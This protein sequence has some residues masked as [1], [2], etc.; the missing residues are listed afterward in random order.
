MPGEATWCKESSK[1]FSGWRMTQPALRQALEL[2]LEQGG[3]KALC[4]HVIRRFPR[5]TTAAEDIVQ[6]VLQEVLAGAGGSGFEVGGGEQRAARHGSLE[7]GDAQGL[8]P[9]HT[10]LRH[11]RQLVRWRALDALRRAE[12]VALSA[13]DQ[14][15]DSSDL[16]AR[17]EVRDRHQL[18][19]SGQYAEAE[20]RREQVLLLSDVLREFTAWCE[21]P[22][23]RGGLVMKELYERRLRGQE[24]A[25]IAAA[26]G[27]A[28]NTADQMLKRARDW[29]L[30]RI[31]QQD[32]D[33][34]VFRTILR[35]ADAGRREV[36]VSIGDVRITFTSFH[37]VVRFVVDEMG[38][39]C[40]GPDRLEEYRQSPHQEGFRDL[41]Y[42]IEEAGCR[43][44]REEVQDG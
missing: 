16:G 41:R 12:H 33:Q 20:R 17:L 40:P 14:G 29:I 42:H 9:R 37:D 27:L 8:L 32:V 15:E 11:L 43:H 4:A 38:A 36:S 34:S 28:R 35:G 6:G 31:R 10:I 7:W 25:Q 23:R 13:L 26:M 18:S 2:F 1:Y 24:M 30:E 44:C 5:L 22:E 21:S 39:L 19:P 3:R